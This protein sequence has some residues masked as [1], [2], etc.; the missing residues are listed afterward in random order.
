MDPPA[1]Q[2]ATIPVQ[3]QASDIVS[4]DEDADAAKFWHS[5][6]HSLDDEPATP[7]KK[8]RRE[9]V[10]IL[11]AEAARLEQDALQMRANMSTASPRVG[12]KAKTQAL[13]THFFDASPVKESA[14]L[15][16][17]AQFRGSRGAIH[18]SRQTPAE[19]V[20]YLEHWPFKRKLEIYLPSPRGKKLHP[21]RSGPWWRKKRNFWSKL[22]HYW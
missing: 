17:M 2:E 6:R 16:F 18:P 9:A 21:R 4:S 5:V 11:L 14:P 7:D 10:P 8:A 15:K 13:F 20:E 1:G 12:T 3:G 22:I 19:K